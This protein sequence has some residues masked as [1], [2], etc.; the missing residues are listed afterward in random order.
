MKALDDMLTYR[1][2]TLTAI[3]QLVQDS[4]LRPSSIMFAP[5]WDE[6]NDEVELIEKN[7]VGSVSVVW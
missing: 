7:V 1:V 5:V 6:L 4:E 2:E 3:L